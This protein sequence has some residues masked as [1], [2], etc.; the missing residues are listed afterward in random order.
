MEGINPE[1]NLANKAV[2]SPEL[3]D[4]TVIFVYQMF[5]FLCP[6]DTGLFLPLPQLMF[7]TK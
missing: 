1:A 2:L 3:C 4:E 5:T 6:A 7:F